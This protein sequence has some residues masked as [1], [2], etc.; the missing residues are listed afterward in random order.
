MLVDKLRPDDAVLY[1]APERDGATV[2][3]EGYLA[4]DNSVFCSNT[5]SSDQITG[6]LLV[7]EGVCIVN[8]D[9]IVPLP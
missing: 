7:G 9:K 6:R 3:T 5:G 2:Q 1:C 4:V 8:L